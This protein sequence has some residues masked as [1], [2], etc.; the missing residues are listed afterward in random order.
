MNQDKT[1]KILNNFCIFQNNVIKYSANNTPIIATNNFIQIIE[2]T[3]IINSYFYKTNSNWHINKEYD[4]KEKKK[5]FNELLI[6]IK[7]VIS[8]FKKGTIAHH[9]NKA[10]K[11]FKV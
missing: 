3:D 1:N 5:Y 4:I 7:E 6:E 11:W 8:K 9:G 2:L 10:K